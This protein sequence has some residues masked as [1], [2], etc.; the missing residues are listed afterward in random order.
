[1][2]REGGQKRELDSLLAD[3]HENKVGNYARAIKGYQKFLGRRQYFL[4]DLAARLWSSGGLEV[5]VNPELCLHLQGEAP[6]ILKLYFG[7]DDPL[8]QARAET[9]LELMSQAFAAEV[10]QG[11]QVAILDVRRPKRFALKNPGKHSALLQG[12]ARSFAEIWSALDN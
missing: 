8:S 3:V 1:M 12:E 10:A 5:R 9:A 7:A 2:H 4:L 11:Y 6:I